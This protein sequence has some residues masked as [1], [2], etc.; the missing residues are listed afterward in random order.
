M[1]ILLKYKDII[2]YYLLFIFYEY[3]YFLKDADSKFAYLWRR[4]LKSPV[5]TPQEYKEVVKECLSKSHTIRVEVIDIFMTPD[6]VSLMWDCIDHKISDYLKGDKTQHQ[7][8]VEKV[9]RD[10]NHRMG[11]STLYKAYSKPWVFQLI[12]IDRNL[13]P[14]Y[15]TDFRVLKTTVPL[16][17]LTDNPNEFICFLKKFP[18]A[19]ILPAGF[20]YNSANKLG[21]TLTA[22]S[23]WYNNRFDVNS[24]WNQFAS[25]M[26]KSD[27]VREYMD[28]IENNSYLPLK[29]EL[30]G[31][32]LHY[33]N[34]T[35]VPPRVSGARNIEW[36]NIDFDYFDNEPIPEAVSTA[37][38]SHNGFN[39]K[40]LAAR[41][42]L[43]DLA[44]ALDPE[45]SYQKFVT[46]ILNLGLNS[47]SKEEL[48][49]FL[50]KT[51]VNFSKYWNKEKLLQT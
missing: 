42:V 33:D 43:K 11:L 47:K 1:C 20:V 36:G 6:Y 29:D 50:Q 46:M 26:P 18:T 48:I 28:G 9:D 49:A 14:Q 25:S 39:K 3:G 10:I 23:E 37:S 32:D 51:D 27:F 7:W 22:V 35:P 38:V 15:T 17:P 40:S 45:E 34:I 31:K 8:I 4:T 16:Q 19:P 2:L 21:T 41:K 24:K 12:E 5:A 44:G 13:T 30:F